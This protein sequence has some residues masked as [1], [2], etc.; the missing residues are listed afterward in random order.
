VQDLRFNLGRNRAETLGEQLAQQG[1]SRRAFMKFASAVAA[2]MALTPS[3]AQTMAENLAN[4]RRQSVI[5]L[6]FQECTGCTESIT[7]SFSPTLEDLI[8]DFISLD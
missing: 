4:A 2:S 3:L 1:I 7:R 8:F 6:S 5:W